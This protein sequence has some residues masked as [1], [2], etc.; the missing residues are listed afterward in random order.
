MWEGRWSLDFCG[1]KPPPKH[2][3]GLLGV[4]GDRVDR[5]LV[6]GQRV[7]DAGG[8]IVPDVD[9]AV[10]RAGPN[11]LAVGRPGHFDEVLLKVVLCA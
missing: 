5:A 7:L 9:V 3:D 6:A 10:R 11:V 8:G 4:E 2:T 1:V